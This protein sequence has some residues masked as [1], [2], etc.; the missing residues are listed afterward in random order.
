MDRS[1]RGVEEHKI[2]DDLVEDL[3]STLEILKDQGLD[4]SKGTCTI[5]GFQTENILKYKTPQEVAQKIILQ[6]KKDL[7]L[8]HIHLIEYNQ[9]GAQTAHDHKE[10]E[11]YSFILYLNDSDGNTVLENYGEITPEKGKLIFFDSDITHYG[12][13]S[14]KGKKIAVGALKKH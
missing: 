5:N 11:D 2:S 13:P 4:T 12:K 9:A 7:N 14:M 10:T 8:F 6:L 1:K 3:L